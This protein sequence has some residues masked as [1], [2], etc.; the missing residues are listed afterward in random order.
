MKKT[1]FTIT[2]A[3]CVAF[4]TTNS[5]AQANKESEQARKELKEA[6]KD[7]YKSNKNLKDAKNDLQIAS[8]DSIDD[9]IAVKQDAEIS[10]AN[11]KKTIAELRAKKSNLTAKLKANYNS[12]IT[13]LERMNNK[14]QYDINTANHTNS[15]KWESFKREF[16][17]DLNELG[18]A[19]KDIGVNNTK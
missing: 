9:Y 5:N 3:I 16:K 14:L 19:L 13:S 8:Q 4:T 18:N 11:N 17:H 12:Q 1:I 15:S 7:V 6:Q 10:I 2:L